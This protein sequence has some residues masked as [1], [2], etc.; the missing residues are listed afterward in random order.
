MLM[1]QLQSMSNAVTFINKR[2][3]VKCLAFQVYIQ[4]EQSENN[5]PAYAKN[6]GCKM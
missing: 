2:F 5:N 6:Q 3:A 1:F 4:L